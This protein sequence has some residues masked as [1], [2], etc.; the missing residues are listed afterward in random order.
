MR[1]EVGRRVRTELHPP[2]DIAPWTPEE[3]HGTRDGVIGLPVPSGKIADRD[4]V[5]LRTALRELTA[6][7]T[8]GQLRVT[9][10]Q[11]LLLFDI[12]PDRIPEVEERLRAHGV[13]L[14]GDIER[15]PPAGDRL[16]R[17]ADLRAGPRRGGTG[18]ARSRHSAGEG[19]RRHRHG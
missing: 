15:A 4:G 11:D 5:S 17:A 13:A 9:P 7:G 12:A 6:D 8:V 14:A 16:P 19:V 10:R 2:V 18:A 1:A 3:Y